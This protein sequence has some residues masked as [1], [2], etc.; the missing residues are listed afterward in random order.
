MVGVHRS[1]IR[2]ASG[3]DAVLSM[4]TASFLVRCEGWDLRRCER[5]SPAFQRSETC[6]VKRWRSG[7]AKNKG[8]ASGVLKMF[9]FHLFFP[10]G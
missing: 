10:R 6:G 2:S 9:S 8:E 1:E 4:H 5:N 7:G 3:E